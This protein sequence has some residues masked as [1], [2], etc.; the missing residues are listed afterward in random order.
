MC[1]SNVLLRDFRT[2]QFE[3]ARNKLG[4][5]PFS[6]ESEIGHIG[7]LAARLLKCTCPGV[8]VRGRNPCLNV[9]SRIS[10]VGGVRKYIFLVL[11]FRLGRFGY[12]DWRQ[13]HVPQS[14]H[15]L[16]APPW[17]SAA[18]GHLWCTP[19]RQATKRSHE[20]ATSRHVR[21]SRPARD[22]KAAMPEWRV[23]RRRFVSA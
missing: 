17:W 3:F 13:T 8:G 15:L 22:L 16:C 1:V 11:M 19:A 21:F 20:R 2:R 14:K 6:K 5:G 7:M 9:S 18:T 4:T 23:V 12:P 10:V